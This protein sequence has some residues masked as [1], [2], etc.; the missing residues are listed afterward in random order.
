MQILHHAYVYDFRFV[1]LLIG[2]STST[3]INGIW[4]KFDAEIK[5]K[6]GILLR[7]IYNVCLKWAYNPNVV[8]P[9]AKLKSI[10]PEIDKD[11]DFES[12]QGHFALWNYVSNKIP[13]PLPRLAR[14][15]PLVFSTWNSLKGGSDTV[16]K[17]I[18]HANSLVPVKSPQ[19]RKSTYA[20]PYF[21]D[22]IPSQPNPS[23]TILK[24][25]L[26]QAS[27]ISRIFLLGA[28]VTNRIYQICTAQKDVDQYPS[29]LHYRDAN[30]HRATIRE[31]LRLMGRAWRLSAEASVPPQS[32]AINAPRRALRS[33]ANVDQREWG[34]AAV[35][36]TPA[37]NVRT[38]YEADPK[39]INQ[40]AVHERRKNCRGL[41]MF[42]TFR[43][44]S[45]QV[46]PKGAGAR[47][48][49]AFC[50]K[51][52]TNVWCAGCHTW[53]CGPHIELSSELGS[54]MIVNTITNPFT[55]IQKQICFRNSCWHE[56][57]KFAY[58]SQSANPVNSTGAQRTL[59]FD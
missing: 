25:V 58:E 48:A 54:S 52:L 14:I 12:F 33:T 44:K 45:G 35:G 31:G 38:F 29:L 26:L 57:H 8:L 27:A 37:R 19:V 18:C 47:G 21:F 20:S 1:L 4:V 22:R 32:A 39:N 50:K 28:I 40:K 41:V 9:E 7:S 2:D 49:C 43:D 59:Q 15:L 55:G 16:T 5:T 30:N 11:L 23:C 56:W 10:L 24:T 51:P 17:L 6:Y 36:N 13:G 53:L 34:A 42:R 3:I 46:H